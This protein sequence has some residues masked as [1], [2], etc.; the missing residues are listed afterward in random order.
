MRGGKFCHSV[1]N[2]GDATK[3]AGKTGMRPT[4]GLTISINNLLLI[5]CALDW[6][7]RCVVLLIDDVDDAFSL[8]P[9]ETSKDPE[10]LKIQRS[11]D[12]KRG[13]Q[14]QSTLPRQEYT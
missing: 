2:N 9:A 3:A 11:E 14:P 6:C 12:P 8:P 4:L 10:D 5:K 1:F 7:Y 13:Q